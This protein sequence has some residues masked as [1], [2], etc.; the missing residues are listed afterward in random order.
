V[1]VVAAGG[2][3]THAQLVITQA[4]AS[5]SSLGM[6]YAVVHICLVRACRVNESTRY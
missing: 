4:V 2:G 3:V 1:V 6:R 5:Y